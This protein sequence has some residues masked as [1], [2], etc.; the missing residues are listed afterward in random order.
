MRIADDFQSLIS[1]L[2]HS[3]SSSKIFMKIYSVVLR[4][5]ATRQRNGQTRGR[6]KHK[7]FSEGNKRA[8]YA[9]HA[10]AASRQAERI[11]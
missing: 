9:D 1:F 7:L 11:L 10:V 8:R 3:Y 4:E 6:V 2:L 5:I